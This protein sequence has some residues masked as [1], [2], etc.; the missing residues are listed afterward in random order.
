M[1]FL[2]TA[3]V[4]N[5]AYAMQFSA[6]GDHEQT[7]LKLTLLKQLVAKSWTL[8]NL[9]DKRFPIGDYLI[10]DGYGSRQAE[11]PELGQHNIS[12]QPK[13]FSA[14][15]GT[16]DEWKLELLI[17]F[18]GSE[19]AD[20]YSPSSAHRRQNALMNELGVEISSLASK[21]HAARLAQHQAKQ[22]AAAVARVFLQENPFE[23]QKMEQPGDKKNQFDAGEDRFDTEGAHE[24]NA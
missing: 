17:E 8:T 18:N 10:N 15:K 3:A 7:Q 11:R 4:L 1:K 5:C 2:L 6:R 19:K 23:E 14:D 12:F 9:G 24:A 22:S 21:L 20:F 16:E 13:R